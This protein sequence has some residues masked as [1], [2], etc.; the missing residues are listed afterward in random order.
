MNKKIEEFVKKHLVSIRQVGK[1]EKIS[2]TEYKTKLNY[3][4]YNINVTKSELQSLITSAV[5]E[6]LQD[7]LNNYDV[8]SLEHEIIEEWIKE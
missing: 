1:T 3:E 4:I 5:S 6:Y 7:K 2:D 8:G